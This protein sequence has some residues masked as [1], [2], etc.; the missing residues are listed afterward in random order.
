MIENLIELQPYASRTFPFKTTIILP[1]T[2]IIMWDV[3]RE[4]RDR[5]LYTVPL[6]ENDTILQRQHKL[7]N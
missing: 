7:I 3:R 1:N 2:M 5:L 6:Y 4:T